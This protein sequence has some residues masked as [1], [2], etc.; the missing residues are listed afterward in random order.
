[1]RWTTHCTI[2][3][4]DR[5][6]AFEFEVFESGMRWGYRFEP[7]GDGTLVTEYR[8]E[9]RKPPPGVKLVQQSGILG[10]DREGLMVDG[11]QATLEKVKAAAESVKPE[12]GEELLHLAEV[13]AAVDVEH[14]VAR[15]P[16]QP[17]PLPV[18]PDPLALLG[19]GEAVAE[20]A[21]DEEPLLGEPHRVGERR[22]EPHRIGEGV[23]VDAPARHHV[24]HAAG[25]PGTTSR[26]SVLMSATAALGMANGEPI[27]DGGQQRG[28]VAAE[29]QAGDADL[30]DALAAR[31][32]RRRPGS[33]GRRGP[34]P[35]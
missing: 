7:E 35:R 33:R 16:V 17:G 1:M 10:K 5:G 4:A 9:I 26:S 32:G 6:K 22:V 12:V 23:G 18:L 27:L 13:G 21:D 30:L 29:R 28:G 15:V 20:A 8:E 2:T 3:K 24:A 34:S 19:R 31:G 25:W 11:M 14:V